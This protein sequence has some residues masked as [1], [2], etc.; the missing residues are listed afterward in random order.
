MTI[1]FTHHQ[2]WTILEHSSPDGM[3]CHGHLHPW[4][5]SA[6]TLSLPDLVGFGVSAEGIGRLIRQA[7]LD[8]TAVNSSEL[9]TG[10]TIT[11]SVEF[12][13]AL[14]QVAPCVMCSELKS[15]SSDVQKVSHSKSPTLV[16]SNNP[17]VGPTIHIHGVLDTSATVAEVLRLWGLEGD[18]KR[19]GT[20]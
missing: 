9:R 6:G 19:W 5:A 14:V 7:E 8:Y 16:E 4:D 18:A 1:T 17:S 13:H 12:L 11:I 15:V 10:E 2:V 3:A 20:C